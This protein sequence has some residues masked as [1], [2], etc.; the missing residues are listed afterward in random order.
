MKHQIFFLLLAGTLLVSCQ[1]K[2]KSLSF[3]AIVR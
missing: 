3:Y 2:K 1:Q